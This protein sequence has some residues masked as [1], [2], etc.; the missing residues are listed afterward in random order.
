MN[1]PP[2]N[3]QVPS[4]IIDLGALKRHGSD[5]TEEQKNEA[6]R[7]ALTQA[8]LLCQQCGGRILDTNLLVHYYTLQTGPVQTPTGIVQGLGLATATCC[9]ADCPNTVHF[10]A[11]AIV[12]RNADGTLTWLREDFFK[13]DRQQLDLPTESDADE[14]KADEGV[15]RLLEDIGG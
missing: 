3:G 2:M 15:E 11:D 14:F 7:Q 4:N 6:A 10:D 9:S 8:G 13:P 5:P 12:R 1:Q